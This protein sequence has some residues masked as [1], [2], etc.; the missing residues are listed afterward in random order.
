MVGLLNLSCGTQVQVAADVGGLPILHR[1]FWV[2]TVDA[3]SHSYRL[4]TEVVEP[5]DLYPIWVRIVI[6]LEAVPYLAQAELVDLEVDFC[7]V[8]TET[9]ADDVDVHRTQG[10]VADDFEDGSCPFQAEAVADADSEDPS[11]KS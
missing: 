4:P 1:S 10:G 2:G 8:Q 3:E 6:G 7:L 9:V 5:E 11:Q